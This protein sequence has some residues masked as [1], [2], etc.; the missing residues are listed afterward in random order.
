MTATPVA[1]PPNAPK[2]PSPMP[3]SDVATAIS[4]DA[5]SSA[6]AGAGVAGDFG[7]QRV[8]SAPQLPHVRIES[9]CPGD[10]GLLHIGQSVI[11]II[12]FVLSCL[13]W[14]LQVG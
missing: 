7:R 14:G 11:V 8:R 1:A 3:G 2:M 10:I 6:G 4:F 5:G 12:A 9:A 13:L